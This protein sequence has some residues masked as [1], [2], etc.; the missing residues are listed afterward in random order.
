MHKSLGWPHCLDG[1]SKQ[2]V[3]LFQQLR[4][5]HDQRWRQQHYRSGRSCVS[6][7]GWVGRRLSLLSTAPFLSRFH[8]WFRELS[9][10]FWHRTL[11]HTSAVRL[12]NGLSAFSHSVWLFWEW[13]FR[14]QYPH[15]LPE[16]ILGSWS[17]RRWWDG[18][19][20]SYILYLAFSQILCIFQL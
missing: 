7:C 18:R 8:W 6:L 2:R 5:L 13:F 3:S 20:A 11:R 16:W 15:V 19:W 9:S 10:L 1:L 14:K 4:Q 17:S 12:R